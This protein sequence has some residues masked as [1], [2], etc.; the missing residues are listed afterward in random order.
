MWFKGLAAAFVAIAST[1]SLSQ[2]AVAA[3]SFLHGALSVAVGAS[4]S[5]A[6]LSDNTVG[7]WGENEWGQLGNLSVTRSAVPVSVRLIASGELLDDVTSIAA[8][9]DFTCALS[10]AKVYCWGHNHFGQLGAGTRDFVAHPWA[11]PVQMTSTD[12]SSDEP[13]VELAASPA[14][15]HAC[16]LLGDAAGTVRCWGANYSGQLGDGTKTNNPTPVETVAPAFGGG[17][18]RIESVKHIAAGGSHSCATI[19]ELYPYVVC[20]GGKR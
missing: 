4:H 15:Y 14:G 6:I 19:N 5:C 1:C 12:G 11:I 9:T 20:W 2:S 17:Y 3:D 13:V 8:G 10:H 16:A 7:C 18:R